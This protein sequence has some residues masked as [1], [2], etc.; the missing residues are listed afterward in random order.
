MSVVVS[1]PSPDENRDFIRS[2]AILSAF[3][4]AAVAVGYVATISWVDPVPRDGTTLVVGRDFLNY[5][6]HGRVAGMPDPGRFYDLA[7]YN[8]ELAALLGPG[9][10][11][12]NLPNPP[13]FMLLAWPF[14]RLDYLPALFCWTVF[15]VGTFGYIAAQR[16]RD[17][18]LLIA[19]A[20]SP[21]AVLALIAGQSSFLTASLL[22]T[23]FA[24]L[25]RR[26]IGAGVLI[27]LLTLKPQ[28]GL[29]L[30]VM[31]VASGRWRVLF[32]AVIATLA[33]V[34]TTTALYGPQV[35]IDYVLKSAPT[36]A[37]ALA[38]PAMRAAP[39]MPTILMNARVAGA[40]YGLAL[41]IQAAF[42]ALAIGAV[43]WAFR[44]RKAADPNLLTA[45]FLACSI[46]ATPY[47]G[48]YDVL[49]LTL[50]ALM[51]LAAGKLDEAGRRIVQL[52]Y[53]LPLIQ[54]GL[55]TLHIPG[56][57]LIAPA[58]ALYALTRLRGA[59]AAPLL[60]PQLA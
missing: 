4:F 21:A 13:N 39:F 18:R 20:F 14:A 22:I 29:L 51:L 5:W 2:L 45:L 23:I 53:W 36:Q 40:S 35:W 60:D 41:A 31:L 19:L 24:W 26:P 50:V 34:A 37:L 52:V 32:V 43:F 33:V 17:P 6:M 55:G 3:F 57:G 10:P 25:D 46:F 27:A 7:T 49:A 9:Y 16:F 30:P 11:G 38:D 48:S 59:Q 28:L 56:P 42:A 12:Q 1:I 8:S 54:I 47:L 44:S 58:F 15:G